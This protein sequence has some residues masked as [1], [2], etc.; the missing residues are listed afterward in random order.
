M[1][2]LNQGFVWDDNAYHIMRYVDPRPLRWQDV[3]FN[4]RESYSALEIFNPAGYDNGVT[5]CL[6]TPSGRYTG[7]FHVSCESAEYPTDTSM[8]GLF[9]IQRLVAGLVDVLRTPGW[10]A[11]SIDPLANAALIG[12]DGFVAP[13]PGRETGPHLA[14]EGA[15]SQ[16]ISQR[17]KLGQLPAR[18]LW[19]DADLR[20]HRVRTQMLDSGVVGVQ[21]PCAAM[22]C[23]LTPRELDVLTLV[24]DGRSNA[25]IALTLAISVK[26]AGKHIEHIMDK[27]GVGS[28]MAA[29]KTALDQGYVT[30]AIG[31]L[32]A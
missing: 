10:I 25:Q 16:L 2:H 15:L 4:Y 19:R 24:A 17:R 7:G 28:R 20:W 30:V 12:D 14:Q 29:A 6:Y 26:T 3:P 23:E 8:E 27:L 31:S 13:L 5:T 18:F 22:P 9:I 21:W 32:G 1:D 11:A